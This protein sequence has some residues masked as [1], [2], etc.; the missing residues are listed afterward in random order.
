MSRPLLG[1]TMTLML[2]LVAAAGCAA[3]PAKPSA[4][5][6]DDDRCSFDSDCPGGSCRFGTCSPFPPDRQACAFDSDCPGGSCRFGTCSPFPPDP[7]GCT[8]DSQCP[9]G[10]RRLGSCSPLPPDA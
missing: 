4:A 7:Q 8:F 10:S 1:R 9:G 2:A 6:A 5:S 3:N